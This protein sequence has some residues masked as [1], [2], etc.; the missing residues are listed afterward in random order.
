MGRLQVRTF[1]VFALIVV[2]CQF[3]WS[4]PGRAATAH[5]WGTIQDTAGNVVSNLNSGN[6]LATYHALFPENQAHQDQCVQDVSNAASSWLSNT[7]RM[8]HTF[9][10]ASSSELIFFYKLGALSWR[11]SGHATDASS[12]NYPNVCFNLSGS[13]F[14]SYYILSLIYTPPGCTPSTSSA[15]YDCG[16]GSSV[17]YGSGS[18]AGS[19]VSIEHSTGTSTSLTAKFDGAL[20]LSGSY[21]ETSTHG[22]E[23]TLSK[24]TNYSITWP[25]T[26]PVSDDGIHHDFDQFEILLNP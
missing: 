5:C 10:A 25:D 26:G 24:E 7:G 17:T 18:S 4:Q 9:F 22:S 11:D 21:S 19:T 13:V 16:G 1:A 2:V 15:G 6:A 23:V 20:S 8:C 3:M 14:P 12:Y